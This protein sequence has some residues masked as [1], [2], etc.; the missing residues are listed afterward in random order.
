M[1][2]TK[3]FNRCLFLDT[4]SIEEVKRWNATGVIDGITTNQYI[5]L[6]D[7]I[8]PSAYYMTVKRICKEMRGKPVSVELTDSTLP[9]E[10]MVHEAK[11]L[12]ALAENIVVK[13]PMIPETTKSLEVINELT[14]ANI[15]VN[16]TTMM[17]FE[18]LALAILAAGRSRKISFVSLFWGRSM[19]DYIKY[20][21]RS[22]FMANHPKVG[23]ASQV[24]SNPQNIVRAAATFIK[25]GGYENIKI[26]A[27]SI[28]TAAMVGLAF[29]AGANIVT[30]APD[31]LM[32]MLFSQRSIE[33]IEQF[34]NAWKQL[35]KRK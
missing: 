12:N 29:E 6:Q 26:I 32:A 34:D 3:N 15:S 33:T 19:E 20:S 27:G 28:R 30:T 2:K 9:K 10:K 11:K 31:K 13:V 8:K 21:S 7:G 18:Q 1:I 24:N 14:R 4:S 17:T 35:Q 25:E 22:D 16:V 23:I 5:M